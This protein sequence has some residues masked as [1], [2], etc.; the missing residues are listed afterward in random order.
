ML[1]AKRV[2]LYYDLIVMSRY[3]EYVNLFI[4]NELF[5]IQ[6]KFKAEKEL[7]R[8]KFSLER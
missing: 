5:V 6:A 2:N 7:R 1:I 4:F 8:R 3:H